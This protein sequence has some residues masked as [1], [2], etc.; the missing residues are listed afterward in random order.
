MSLVGPRPERMAYVQHFSPEIYRYSDRHRVKSGLTG[1]AQINGL[2]GSTSLADRVE[3]DNHYIE[4]WS[5]WMDFKIAMKTLP[6]VLRARSLPKT[7]ETQVTMLTRTTHVVIAGLA[8]S[9][10]LG[11]GGSALAQTTTPSAASTPSGTSTQRPPPRGAHDFHARAEHPAPSPSETSSAPN[12]Y[13]ESVPTATGQEQ[14]TER[15]TPS[16]SSSGSSGEAQQQSATTQE[17]PPVST[18]PASPDA[19]KRAHKKRVVTG[20]S[21]GRAASPTTPQCPLGRRRRRPRR[22]P[23]AGELRPLP[24]AGGDVPGHRRLDDRGRRSA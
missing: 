1:W 21:G 15:S 14:V 5:L 17:D 20:S 18:S 19:P 9:A 8:C 10:V 23:R 3:W 24:A 11:L 16:S 6:A 4:N 12:E 22:L 2:R 13:V 7:S